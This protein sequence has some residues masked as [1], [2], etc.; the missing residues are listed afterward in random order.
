[1]RGELLN[2]SFSKS[3]SCGEGFRIRFVRKKPHPQALLH[4]RGGLI[5]SSFSK[6][7]LCGEGFRMRFVRKKPHP[8]PLSTREGSF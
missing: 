8:Q 1:M 6:S 5:N 3:F 7:F 2:S 4:K